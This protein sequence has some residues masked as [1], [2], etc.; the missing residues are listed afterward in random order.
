[1][2]TYKRVLNNEKV[3]E[4]TILALDKVTRKGKRLEVEA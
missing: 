3:L 2:R 4:Q 1:M